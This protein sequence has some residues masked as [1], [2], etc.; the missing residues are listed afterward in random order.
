MEKRVNLIVESLFGLDEF[1]WINKENATKLGVIT[2]STI[3]YEDEVSGIS[4]TA[5]VEISDQVTE[6]NI[7]VDTKLVEKWETNDKWF[8]ALDLFAEKHLKTG[9]ITKPAPATTYSPPK[10]VYSP[11]SQVS[12]PPITPSAP[13]AVYPTAASVERSAEGTYKISASSLL[14]TPTTT[15]P[16]PSVPRI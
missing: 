10:S 15:T 11:P 4:G 7:A 8:G 2:G 5:T 12:P 13:P 14:S 9:P 1:V 16:T 3:Y 6:F